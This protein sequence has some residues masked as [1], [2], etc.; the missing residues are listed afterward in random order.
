MVPPFDDKVSAQVRQKLSEGAQEKVLTLLQEAAK[1]ADIDID[2]RY[3]SFSKEGN[4]PAV[5]PP[6]AQSTTPAAPV[7]AP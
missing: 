4:A 1:Q 3:G 5:R 7:P 6:Q 2:P